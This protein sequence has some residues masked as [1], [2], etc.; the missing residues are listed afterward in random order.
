MQGE[1]RSGGRIKVRDACKG[2]GRGV[3]VRRRRGLVHKTEAICPRVLRRFNLD[4]D[5]ASWV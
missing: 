4:L 1:Q 2:R 5:Q 3:K